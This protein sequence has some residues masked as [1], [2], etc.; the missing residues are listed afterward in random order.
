V[1]ALAVPVPDPRAR[2]S[3]ARTA[4]R[5]P[6]P[7]AAPG[8]PG[9]GLRQGRYRG[10]G[11]SWLI[12][13]CFPG[14]GRDQRDPLLTG[15][16]FDALLALGALAFPAAAVGERLVHEYVQVRDSLW[17]GPA[18]WRCSATACIAAGVAPGR[19]SL[20]Q[21]EGN[22]QSTRS[23]TSPSTPTRPTCSS[24]SSP[25]ATNRPRSWSPRTCPS[26]AGARPSPTTSS[27]PQ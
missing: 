1:T 6:G 24:S 15:Q 16:G 10:P 27:P 13:N 20:S 22:T 21:G 12:S 25:P 23:A 8:P 7:A 19:C 3:A 2:S 18:R 9:P 26:G 17:C 4:R 5:S 11:H 14:G